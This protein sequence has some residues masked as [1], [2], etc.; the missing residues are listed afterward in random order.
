MIKEKKWSGK[1]FR[2]IMN[3]FR[4]DFVLRNGGRVGNSL[5]AECEERLFSAVL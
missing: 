5:E 3:S 4:E 2:D 1:C